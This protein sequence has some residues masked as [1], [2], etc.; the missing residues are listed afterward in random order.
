MLGKVPA[1]QNRSRYTWDPQCV[2]LQETGSPPPTCSQRTKDLTKL[3]HVCKTPSPPKEIPIHV[4]PGLNPQC[5]P[6]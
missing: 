2:P 6:L 5:G 3:C 4:G 1:P